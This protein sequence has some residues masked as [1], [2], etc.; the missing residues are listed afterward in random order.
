MPTFLSKVGDTFRIKGR[1]IVI[2]ALTR[3]LPQSPIRLGDWI[4]F[5][6]PS[7]TRVRAEIIGFEHMHLSPLPPAGETPIGIQLKL[8]IDPQLLAGQEAWL[9]RASEAPNTEGN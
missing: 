8:D 6:D 5:H 1:G 3:E 4:E 2:V 7:N 9:V